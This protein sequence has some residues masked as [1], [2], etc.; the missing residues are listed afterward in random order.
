MGAPVIEANVNPDLFSGIIQHVTIP[1]CELSSDDLRQLYNRLEGKANEAAELQILSTPIPP[2]MTQPQIDERNREIRNVLRLTVRVQSP[3]GEWTGGQTADALADRNLPVQIE[4]VD[5]ITNLFYRGRFNME[6]NNWFTVRL[7]FRRPSILDFSNLSTSASQ[8]GSAA[9][10]SGVNAT[11]AN[12][13]LAEI[14]RFFHE[15]RTLRN[16]LHSPA[17]YDALVLPIGF[18]LSLYAVAH[19]DRILRARVAV[20]EA[21]FVAVDV[22]VV[23]LALMAFRLTFNYIRWIAPKVEGPN[24][25]QGALRLHKLFATILVSTIVGTIIKGLLQLLMPR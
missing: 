9:S 17:A 25:A 24:R 15:R 12:G 20:P 14:T 21:I 13:C 7:D 16:W 8:N 22:Y 5:F 1:A 23:L 6:P 11:W 2:G 18:P 4:T 3:S 10:V 19:L